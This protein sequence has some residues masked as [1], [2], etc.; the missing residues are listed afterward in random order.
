[1]YLERW[2]IENSFKRIKGKFGL[3]KVRVL[4]YQKLLNLIALTLF[5]LAISTVIYQRIQKLNHNLVAGV[6]LFYKQFLKHYSLSQNLDSFIT[7]L[8]KS[9]SPLI[10]KI[11]DPPDQ[12]TLFFNH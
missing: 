8:Q 4:Q 5:S 2:G 11:H 9:I 10:T 12:L 3:E 7:F 6:L 1:M